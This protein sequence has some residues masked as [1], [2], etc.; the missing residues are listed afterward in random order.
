M[1]LKNAWP[2]EDAKEAE[3]PE[4]KIPTLSRDYKGPRYLA[5]RNRRA[6]F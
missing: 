1:V 2:L 6:L 5:D 4:E 3:S